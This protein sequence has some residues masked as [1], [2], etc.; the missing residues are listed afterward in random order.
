M[1]FEFKINGSDGFETIVVDMEN[2]IY[3]Y[4]DQLKMDLKWAQR[5]ITRIEY[6]R[7][8]DE[9]IEWIEN[10]IDKDERDVDT[11]IVCRYI[12]AQSPSA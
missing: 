11:Y 5:F 3:E 12:V 8:G 2:Y 9:L 4:K 10:Y 1:E 7:N 6:E